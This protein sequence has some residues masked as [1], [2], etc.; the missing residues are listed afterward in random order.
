MGRKRRTPEQYKTEIKEKYGNEYTLLSEYVKSTDKIH[1]RHN[2]CGTEWYPNAGDLMKKK[3]CPVCGKKQLCKNISKTP[4]QFKKEFYELSNGEYELLSEY[5]RSNINV[6]IKHNLCGKEFEMMPQKYLSGQRCP[7]CR[8]N[9][10]KTQE[11]FEN[12]VYELYGDEFTVVGEFKN[13]YTSIDILHNKCNHIN[14][15]KPSDFLMKKTFC[16]FCNQSAIESLI[17]KALN[18][19]NIEYEIQKKFDGLVGV[20]GNNLSY[21]FYFI[22]NNNEYLVEGQGE[23]HYH[24]VKHFGDKAKF[25]KQQEHDKRKR[26]YAESNNIILIEIPYWEYKNVKEII[27]SRLLLQQSA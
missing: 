21:D 2:I 19:M 1:V 5:Y 16:K 26:D 4:E 20:R 23:Q 10:K 3:I 6:K 24:V 18:E 9:R 13:T 25:E 22:Y 8:P 7:H 17:E 12:E 27:K 14:N 15:V 11:E